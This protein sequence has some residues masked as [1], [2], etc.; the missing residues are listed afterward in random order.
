MTHRMGKLMLL[1]WFASRIVA[2]LYD[3]NGKLH[4]GVISS[5]QHEDSS[6]SSFN[7]TL[8]NGE[9]FHLRTID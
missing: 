6:G 1:S 3:S 7:I 2:I 4:S 5:I 9:V 8:E